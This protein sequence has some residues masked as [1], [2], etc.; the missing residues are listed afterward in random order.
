[1]LYSR[2]NIASEN[3]IV[4]SAT[5]P[6]GSNGP[7]DRASLRARLIA[8]RE[9]LPAALHT[10]ASTRIAALLADL[11]ARTGALTVGFCWP[12]RGEFDCRGVI[13][14]WLAADE[15]RSAAL[16]VILQTAT[17]MVFRRWMPQGRLIAG[18]YDIP[19]PQEDSRVVPDLVLMPTVGFDAHGYRLGYGGGY[20]DRTLAA[21]QPR[22]LAVGVGF[23]L[24]R[25]PQIAPDPHDIP[26]DFVITEAGLFETR[27]A[28]K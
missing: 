4:S 19:V 5:D 15:R 17:P 12:Y 1:M 24:A 21:L 6:P 8:A 23:E 9:T 20:F 26:M 25:L 28:R 16:P 14:D 22:P 2:S 7:E 11:L 27:T 10:A 13:A 18:R 3:S